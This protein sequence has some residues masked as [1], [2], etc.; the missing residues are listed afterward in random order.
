MKTHNDL[1]SFQIE[2]SATLAKVKLRKETIFRDIKKIKLGDIIVQLSRSVVYKKVNATVIRQEN[3]KVEREK[4]TWCEKCE[5]FGRA[6][7]ENENQ[8]ISFEK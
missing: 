5:K 7:K 4:L 3:V 8:I 1:T 2:E 6:N